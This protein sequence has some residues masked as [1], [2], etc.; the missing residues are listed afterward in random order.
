MSPCFLGVPSFERTTWG[1]S[2]R[3][4]ISPTVK[5]SNKQPIR[6]AKL[7]VTNVEIDFMLILTIWLL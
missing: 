1:H 6:L 2:A 4:C 5:T 7:F 3:A